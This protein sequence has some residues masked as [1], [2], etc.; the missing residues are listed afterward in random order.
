MKSFLEDLD[1]PFAEPRDKIKPVPIWNKKL[2]FM[3]T[4][5]HTYL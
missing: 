4:L 3:N 2:Y 5:N 1:V